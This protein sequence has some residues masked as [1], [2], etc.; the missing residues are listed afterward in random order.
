MLTKL[1][2]G[3]FAFTFWTHSCSHPV[4]QE[5]DTDLLPSDTL[6]T[7]SVD[8]AKDIQ[9]ILQSHCTPCH[10]EGGKMYMRMPFDKP[11]TIYDHGEA[12]LRRI[13]GE[14]EVKKLKAFLSSQAK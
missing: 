13:K 4:K 5:S 11:K 7:A 6:Q 8:F 12:I 3:I 9:P 14:D 2:V 10:F 1:F